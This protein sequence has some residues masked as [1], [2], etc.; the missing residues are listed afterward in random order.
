MIHSI[1]NR[2]VVVQEAANVEPDTA[3]P[4]RDLWDRRDLLVMWAI[5][6][7]KV[8]YKQSL[9]GVAWA[10]LQPLVLMLVFTVV[11][12]HLVRVPAEGVP[13]PLFCY[14]ALL[15]WTFLA[16]SI[17]FAAPSMINN[18][19]L[20]SKVYFPREI[21]PIATVAAAFADF[22]IASA[23]FAGMA[24]YYGTPA[25]P[26]LL[27]LPVLLS[28]Q[29]ALVLGIVLYL[30][31]LSVRFRD[32]RFVVPLGV[33]IWMFASPIIYPSSM[34]PARWQPLYQLN[35]MV[36]IIGGCRSVVIEG[37]PPDGVA[38]LVSVLVSVSLLALGY[39]Y[40][41][42]AEATFADII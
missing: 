22:L 20:V 41:K 24:V 2:A 30:S 27:W 8:R 5:R 17:S 9:L 23:V 33:Q 3:G 13:Y 38:F 39:R 26:A 1:Q 7:I 25:T 32:V 34:V 37:R 15:P 21:L 11:F 18:V 16:T 14:T 42:R 36:G 40:F 31:A 28:V 12:S 19:N 29:I 10:I 35:P 6:E 4:F